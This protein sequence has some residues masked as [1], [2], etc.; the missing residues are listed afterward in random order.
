MF[1]T[2]L[3]TQSLQLHYLSFVASKH[4]ETILS[5]FVPTSQLMLLTKYRMK[6]SNIESILSG[7]ALFFA[8]SQ[9]WCEA[10][11]SK[12]VPAFKNENTQ[13]PS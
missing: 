2:P 3:I 1:Y 13:Y 6:S 12:I 10:L 4:P 5:S 11:I 7:L 9:D 8:I